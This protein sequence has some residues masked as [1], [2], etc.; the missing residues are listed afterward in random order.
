MQNQEG[1]ILLLILEK[2]KAK[3]LDFRGYKES[4]LKRR[5]ERRLTRRKVSSYEEY[6][7]VLD[8]DAEEYKNLINDLT[9][10]VTEFFRDPEAWQILKTKIETRLRETLS[11]G[12][13][14]IW[15][16][17]CSTGE[18]TYSAAILVDQVLEESRDAIYRVS[19]IEIWGTD[20]DKNSLNKAGEG[21]YSSQ[22]I[23]VLPTDILNKYFV[24]NGHYQINER[25]KKRV[26]F[27]FQ[28]LIW[29]EPLKEV[30]LIICRNVLIYFQKF[31]QEK[32]L[33][34]FYHSLKPGGY[35][36]LGKAET[37]IG[38]ARE[39]FE[40]IDRHWKIYKK[41]KAMTGK[42]F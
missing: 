15:S 2:I 40:V 9:I 25:L 18:E 4:T 6:L 28:D 29:G 35:L 42:E 1:E 3:G 27:K 31:W 24:L 20:I 10:K 23:K 33:M 11:I 8:N 32:I 30:D 13:L 36:F 16:A 19:K 12:S 22:T 7:R 26:H 37:L 14:H 39:R 17:G 34:N 38:P 5:I 41:E 21:I